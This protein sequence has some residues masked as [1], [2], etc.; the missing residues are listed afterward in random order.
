ML[1]EIQ[2]VSESLSLWTILAET[3]D[4]KSSVPGPWQ[5]YIHYCPLC[6]YAIQQ[7]PNRM[8]KV[9]PIAWT[10][11][12]KG[13]CCDTD[14]PYRLWT[15]CLSP[16]ARAKIAKKIVEFLFKNSMIINTHFQC[17]LY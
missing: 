14:S 13:L 10:G 5:D 1:T 7:E 12:R 2:S 9:C 8:C 6:Q 17:S 3:G 11:G 15:L 16:W 4:Y